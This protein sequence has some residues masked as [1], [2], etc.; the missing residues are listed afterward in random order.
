M[1]VYSEAVPGGV[2][3]RLNVANLDAIFFMENQAGE[4]QDN[5]ICD[6]T[7]L[8][9]LTISKYQIR[10]G[11]ECAQ[12]YIIYATCAQTGQILLP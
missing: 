4:V 12:L 10:G 7:E 2:I 8:K 11:V 3:G 9:W 1:S 6:Q 5:A